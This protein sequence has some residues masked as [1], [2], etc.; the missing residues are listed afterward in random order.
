MTA[1]E[2]PT[3]TSTRRVRKAAAVLALTAAAGATALVNAPAA[4]AASAVSFCFTFA[5]PP[6]H[7]AYANRPVYL[8][9]Q[10]PH[11][12]DLVKSGTTN[13]SGCGTFYN[14]PTNTKLMVRAYTAT[15]YQTWDGWSQYY[16]PTG[17]AGYSLGKGMVYRTR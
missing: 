1:T 2:N 16:A 7:S 6:A 13:A 15:A 12:W 9:A 8:Y 11:G 4:S 10:L 14:T 3:R 5:N 17:S